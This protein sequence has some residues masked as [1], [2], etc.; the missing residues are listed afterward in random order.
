MRVLCR[1]EPVVFAKK[2][3]REENG[4]RGGRGRGYGGRGGPPP[5]S[6][7]AADYKRLYYL[8]KLGIHPKDVELKRGLVRLRVP[9]MASIQKTWSCR[10]GWCVSAS[11]I[12]Q[13]CVMSELPRGLVCLRTRQVSIFGRLMGRH[14]GCKAAIFGMASW[15]GAVA[16]PNL[17]TLW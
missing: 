4:G 12:W 11:L 6:A 9:N 3:A 1:H 8:Q 15:G 10:A 14:G 13:P 17:A 5:V 2:M 7:E 16:L